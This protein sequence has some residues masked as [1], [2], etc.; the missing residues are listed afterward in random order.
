MPEEV[1][2]QDQWSACSYLKGKGISSKDY[3]TS[4]LKAK[5]EEK[6]Q[7][8]EGIIWEDTARRA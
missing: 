5:G 4:C 7:H 3:T 1:V 6:E 2:K 8:A